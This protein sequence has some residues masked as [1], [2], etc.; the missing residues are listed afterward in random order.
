MGSKLIEKKEK[1]ISTGNR[2][3]ISISVI[4]NAMLREKSRWSCFSLFVLS[5]GV[6]LSGCSATSSIDLVSSIQSE[7]GSSVTTV[8]SI[9]SISEIPQNACEV[10]TPEEFSLEKPLT[11]QNRDK[12]YTIKFYFEKT[13]DPSYPDTVPKINLYLSLSN[14]ANSD[15]YFIGEY[16]SEMPTM[17]PNDLYVTEGE[18]VATCYTW[19]DSNIIVLVVLKNDELFIYEIPTNVSVEDDEYKEIATIKLDLTQSEYDGDRSAFYH[20]REDTSIIKPSLVPANTSKPFHGHMDID[21]ETEDFLYGTWKISKLLDLGP[22][23]SGLP[24]S[25]CPPMADIIDAEIILEKDYFSTIGL[26]YEAA[27]YLITDSKRNHDYYIESIFYNS[28]SFYRYWKLDL[29]DENLNDE[30]KVICVR[31]DV[32]HLMFFL[33]NNERIFLC[34]DAM[35]FELERVV[36]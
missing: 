28:D 13:N 27:G 34:F 9:Q 35:L 7:Y 18:I 19:H 1:F 23:Y 26:T 6:V 32:I 8:T 20:H 4:L 10:E 15:Y 14:N 25:K 11:F 21:A 22:K 5:L 29:P 12:Q 36:D 30:I 3:S 31:L 24:E 17:F 33:V 2:N 16:V